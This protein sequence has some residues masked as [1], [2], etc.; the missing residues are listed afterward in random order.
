MKAPKVPKAKTWVTSGFI[1]PRVKAG[2]YK[3]VLIKGKQKYE[4]PFKVEYDKESPYSP[5]DRKLQ[6]ET[7]MKLYDLLQDLA[8]TVYQMEQYKNYCD[9]MDDKYKTGLMKSVEQ[10]EE[11]RKKSVVT[12]GD[13]YVGMA[14]PRLREK[15]SKL[16]GDVA[17]YYGAPSNAQLANLKS[18]IKQY[19]KLENKWKGIK[20]KC[21]KK[22]EKYNLP[23]VEMKEFDDFIVN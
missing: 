22:I 19:D 15:M 9:N 13:N 17:G 12:T 2:D 21:D 4:Y 6:Y 5:Q 10:I 11:L 16:F 8:Y 23:P 18:L 1:Q 14:E 3:V 7:T 20:T